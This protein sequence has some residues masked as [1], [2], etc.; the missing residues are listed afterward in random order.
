MASSST[1][2]SAKPEDSADF[3]AIRDRFPGTGDKVY[4][5]VAARG[6][7]SRAT[8]AALDAYLD[9]LSD[10]RVDKSENLAMIERVREKFA[11][12]IN[13]DSDE[14]AITKNVSEGLNHIAGALPW[15][16]GDNVVLC[17]DLEHPNNIYPWL[18][19]QRR[20]G[21]E[22]RV[23]PDRDGAIDVDAMIDA[24]D[25]R[26]R[27]VTASTVT[28][29]PGLRT[30]IEPLGRACR[31]SGAFFLVD[32]VQSVGVIDTD[33]RALM[34]DGLAVSTQ[35]ALLGLY[36]MGLLY[37]RR[38]WAEKLTPVAL[39][40]FSV[41]LGG[42]A[43]EATMGDA[44][45]DLMPGARRFDI[46][47]YNYPAACAVEPALDLL[48]EVGQ[49]AIESYVCGLSHRLAGGLHQLG[50][51]V[52]GGPPGPHLAHT[53]TAGHYAPNNHDAAGD[54]ETDALY[55]H[56]TDNDVILTVRRGMLRFS[57]HL[58]NNE[59]DVDRVLDL[60]REWCNGGGS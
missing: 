54:A 34:V 23:V 6:L 4:M 13:A 8:R 36:G 21:I 47:N 55:N 35:K 53:V 26:T 49:P 48:L 59:A 60:V 41:D 58:Y 18:N 57:L 39:A 22:V 52:S 2:A 9:E 16:V 17:R 33:V 3:A 20:F 25:D 5:N 32:A 46:G 28:F 27:L 15:Q 50:V 42:D 30:A 11:Q 43:H 45:Y 29:A 44:T 51:P 10:G 56:L 38:E 14:I 19:L 31:D 1:A 24:I 12:L 40:R 7:P 37:C